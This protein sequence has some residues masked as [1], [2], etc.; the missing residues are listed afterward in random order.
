MFV[1]YILQH[2]S[3]GHGVM[4]ASIAVPGGSIDAML[5]GVCSDSQMVLGW[6][7]QTMQQ[8]NEA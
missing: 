3:E 1:L 2:L 8:L 6:A 4:V 7:P 5:C